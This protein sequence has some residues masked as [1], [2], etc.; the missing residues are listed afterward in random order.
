MGVSRDTADG[1]CGGGEI[2]TVGAGHG[3]GGV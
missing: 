2:A 1:V 3:V